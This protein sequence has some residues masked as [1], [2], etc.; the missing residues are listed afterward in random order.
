VVFLGETKKSRFSHPHTT[1]LAAFGWDE[2]DAALAATIP[3]DGYA[4]PILFND[5]AF[6][7]S[8]IRSN[9]LMKPPGL[10]AVASEVNRLELNEPSY[11]IRCGPPDRR[12]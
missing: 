3:F 8:S 7:T 12:H 11:E 9:H 6:C 1:A 5:G 4:R 10:N 2:S